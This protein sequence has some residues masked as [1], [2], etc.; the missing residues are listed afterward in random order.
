[1]KNFSLAL[2]LLALAGCAS[3]PLT[4]L[5]KLMRLDVET[6]D[7]EALELAVILPDNVGVKPE[8]ARL[9]IALEDDDTGETIRIRQVVDMPVRT[10]DRVLQRA[11][12]AGQHVHR[13]K[14]S[15]S[16]AQALRTFRVDALRMKA[17]RDDVTATFGASVGFCRLDNRTFPGCAANAGL[18]QD[19]GR[20]RLLSTSTRADDG[21][22][23]IG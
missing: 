16:A 9:S 17:E 14:L 10:P 23:R 6:I 5:P 15:E 13:F 8:T 2:F 11:T 21:H 22:V 20:Q 4:S 1:M 19:T 12:K 3:I 7:P 18:Y